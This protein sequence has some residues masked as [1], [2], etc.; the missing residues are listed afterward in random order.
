MRQEAE[1]INDGHHY[2][3]NGGLLYYSLRGRKTLEILNSF[4]NMQAQLIFPAIVN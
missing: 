1:E 2:P 3:L 4:L